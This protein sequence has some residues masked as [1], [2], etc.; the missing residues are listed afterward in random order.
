[1]TTSDLH[2]ICIPTAFSLSVS[3]SSPRLIHSATFSAALILHL[4]LTPIISVCPR[5]HLHVTSSSRA[6]PSRPTNFTHLTSLHLARL[7]LALTHHYLQQPPPLHLTDIHL[8]QSFQYLTL[9]QLKIGHCLYHT[10]STSQH[11]ILNILPDIIHHDDHRRSQAY[12]S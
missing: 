2:F 9:L 5:S 4:I 3:A 6:S 11:N 7:T 1:M 10:F 8:H 12:S